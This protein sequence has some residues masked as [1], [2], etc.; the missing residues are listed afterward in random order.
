MKEKQEL[1]KQLIILSVILGI[2]IIIAILLNMG[3]RNDERYKN[4]PSITNTKENTQETSIEDFKDRLKGLIEESN[5]LKEDNPD[6]Q[7]ENT[8]SY[9]GTDIIQLDSGE[10]VLFAEDEQD[11]IDSQE[12]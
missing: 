7:K 5:T 9:D 8:I 10:I 1:K 12:E 6:E 3:N 11:S 2:V 4:I